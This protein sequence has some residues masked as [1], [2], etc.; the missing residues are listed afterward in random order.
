MIDWKEWKKEI[1]VYCKQR[2]I[3][4][5]PTKKVYNGARSREGGTMKI[6]LEKYSLL[7]AKFDNYTKQLELNDDIK[8]DETLVRPL[9][10]MD[11]LFYSSKGYDDETPLYYMYNGVYKSCHEE[12]F[13]K[14]GIKYEY[15]LI[16]PDRINKECIKTHGHIHYCK[17]GETK[18]P[19]EAF[20]IIYGEGHFVLFEFAENKLK[21]FIIKTKVGDKFII[22]GKYYHYTVNTGSESFVFS[23]LLWE[24]AAGNYNLL[25]EYNGGPFYAFESQGRNCT[26]KFNNRYS[27]NLEIEYH[28]PDTLPWSSNL[29]N[30]PLY[31]AFIMEPERF[32][33]L[34]V[35]R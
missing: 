20:E 17:N 5:S 30:S 22:P 18:R 13:K 34:K 21:V 8:I 14:H 11:K 25:K 29:P 12:I 10:A 28:T 15:T 4:L 2:I 9:K 27:T 1:G 35:E 3:G 16:L 24:G 33:F 26:W 19:D 32:N 31:S 6:D 23:D 7:K